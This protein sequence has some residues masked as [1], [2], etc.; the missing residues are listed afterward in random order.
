MRMA[1]ISKDVDWRKLGLLLAS[2]VLI[3]IFWDSRISYPLRVLVVF[4]HE[5]SHALAA[6]A[7]GGSVEEISV[8]KEV[9]GACVTAGGSRFLILTSGYLGSLAWGGAILLF[10]ARTRFDRLLMALLGA[11]LIAVS[12]LFVRPFQGFGFIFGAASGAVLLALAAY[13]PGAANDY[14]LRVIGLSST[15]YAI[16][17]LKDDVL[18]RPGAP[19]DARMLA[20]LTGLP[21]LVWGLLWMGIALAATLFFLIQVSKA[22]KP[23]GGIAAIGAMPPRSGG[24]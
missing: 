6:W 14:L 9:G 16:L 3:A 17:D 18:D 15:M 4:F 2:L 5:L 7:T 21:A 22:R 13:L 12:L 10:A 8:V 19:S 20:E 23:A 1:M 11:I 24:A